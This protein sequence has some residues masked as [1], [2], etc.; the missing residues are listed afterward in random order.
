MEYVKFEDF[1][2]LQ[3]KIAKVLKVEDHPN[4]DKLYVLTVTTGMAEKVIV[5]G[6]KMHYKPEELVGK[7]VV[8]I[9]NLEPAVIRGVASNG[10]LLATKDA[11]SLAVLAPDKE[12]T[13]G[14]PVS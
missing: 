14:S 3:L 1:K 7:Q 4:A 6:I 8:I 13:T 12:I 5:A 10:M 11:S 2:K 9:D